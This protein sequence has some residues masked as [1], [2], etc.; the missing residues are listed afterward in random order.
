M[1]VVE[2]IFSVIAPHN[3]L[4]CGAE[5]S[6]VCAWCLPDAF[7]RLPNRCYQ[8]HALTP[9]SRVCKNC[10][11][12]S[13]LKNVWVMSEYENVAKNLLHALKFE[14]A[15]AGARIIAQQLDENLPYLQPHT[16]V[17]HVPTASTRRRNRGY[18]QA[19]L[20]ARRF[21][22]LR[23]LQH[24][25]LLVRFGQSRQVG[26]DRGSRLKQLENAFRV[27]KLA[28]VQG[29]DIVLVDDVLTTGSTLEAAAR[30]LKEAGAS[31]VSAAVFASAK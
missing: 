24:R 10:R 19:E 23:K 29:A 2:Q 20:M 16:I 26:A 30:I 21:A 8:C 9:S 31:S 28:K 1:N 12:K 5:G 3:C 7:P 14:R 22:A 15:S 13:N 27:V 17:V 11:R 4:I 25:G 18:D 6:V